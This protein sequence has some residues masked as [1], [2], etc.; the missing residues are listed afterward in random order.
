MSGCRPWFRFLISGSYLVIVLSCGDSLW[1]WRK[2]NYLESGLKALLKWWKGELLK[3]NENMTTMM[4][5]KGKSQK[6]KI[7]L[8]IFF[9]KLPK[10]LILAWPTTQPKP[11]QFLFLEIITSIIHFDKLSSHPFSIMFLLPL[12]LWLGNS[13]LYPSQLI[14][15]LHS[16]IWSLFFLL[17]CLFLARH[18]IMS[19]CV[20][21][22]PM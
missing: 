4:I 15:W 20:R 21:H 7:E 16:E 5:E 10:L 12:N 9:E 3:L 1:C 19:L 17:D 2:G 11:S 18:C 14:L 22:L 13:Q 6:Y 8:K